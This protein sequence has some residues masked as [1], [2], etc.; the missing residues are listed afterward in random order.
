MAKKEAKKAK[1]T[2]KATK[3]PAQAKT[4]KKH[5]AELSDDD[6]KQVSGG[7]SFALEAGHEKWIE[8]VSWPTGGS[9]Q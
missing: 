2:K 7:S 4:T 3:A 1:G 9:S 8:I 6:L 5:D